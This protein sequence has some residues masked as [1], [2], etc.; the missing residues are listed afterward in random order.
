MGTADTIALGVQLV[1]SNESSALTNLVTVSSNVGADYTEKTVT[2]TG[3]ALNTSKATWDAARLRILQDYT[4]QGTAD[5]TSRLRVSAVSTTVASEE[6]QDTFSAY[7]RSLSPISY[8]R[9][10]DQ[11]GATKLYDELRANDGTTVTNVTFQR[12]GL[13]PAWSTNRAADFNGTSSKLVVPS[14]TS[15]QFT[16][17]FT[18]HAIVTVDS[19]GEQRIIFEK[20]GAADDNYGMSILPTGAVQLYIHASGAWPTLT[21]S[22][23]VI[24]APGTYQVVGTYNQ[25]SLKIYVNG[26]EQASLGETRAITTATN[27]PLNIGAGYN[28]GWFDGK[29]DE[30]AV[31][32][33]ALTMTQIANLYTAYT[34]SWSTSGPLGTGVLDDF[35]R[36][37][38]SVGSSW[39][40][41][42]G[43]PLQL[44]SGQ[45]RGAGG[46][47]TAFWNTAQAG[48]Q[49]AFATI[50]VDQKYDNEYHYLYLTD[51]MAAANM[52]GYAVEFDENYFDLWRLTAG[53]WTRLSL[54]S[55][56]FGNVHNSD[57]FVS[58]DGIALTI[59]GTTVVL[60]RRRAGVWSEMGRVTDQTH[61]PA[62]MYRGIGFPVGVTYTRYDDFGGGTASLVQGASAFGI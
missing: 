31:W 47:D 14:S 22:A 24:N 49:E 58:G 7:L 59:E 33:S 55:R 46:W 39:T 18:L 44:A 3:A 8:W 51:S 15:L 54:F 30:L 42:E 38:G 10:S 35:N 48:P 41:S 27:Q 61:R 50:A 52:N 9:M 12:A 23:G 34:G 37:D 60:Y 56:S 19:L 16:T 29:L 57:Y 11:S 32:R 62:S 6:P 5:A 13:L 53:S 26:V 1:Q 28:S 40:N 2:L 36:A 25:N 17:G 4:A 21:T 20:S 43:S 45:L